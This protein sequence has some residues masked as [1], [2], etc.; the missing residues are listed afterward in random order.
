MCWIDRISRLCVRAI[1]LALLCGVLGATTETQAR[2]AEATPG[3]FSRALAQS[4]EQAP[5]DHRAFYAA[6]ALTPLWIE[7][8][9][10][11]ARDLITALKV[12]GAHAL[13]PAR[14]APERLEA[15]MIASSASPQHAAQAELALTRAYL[16]YAR[17]VSS[18]LLDPR[19]VSSMIRRDAPRP[20]PLALLRAAATAPDMA[21]HLAALAPAD[22]DYARL[23]AALAALRGQAER[24]DW[25]APLPS[26]PTL[27]QGDAGPRVALMRARLVRLGDAAPPETDTDPAFFDEGLAQA[28]RRFQ[29]RHGLDDDAAMGPLT[30]AALNVSAAE[31]ASQIAVNLERMRWLNT[32]LGE[33]RIVVNQADFTVKLIDGDATLFHERVV[34]GTLRD[35][36]PEFSDEMEYLVLNPSWHVPRSIATREI[37]P[38]LKE[39]P[40]YL[41]DRNMLLTRLDGAPPPDDPAAHDFTRYS[42]SDFPYRIRQR[43]DAGNALGRVKFMFPNDYA[44]YLHD[45][46]AKRLFARAMR[47][48]SHGCVRV[49]DPLRLAELLLAP[50]VADAPGFVASVLAQGRERYVT[51][52]QPVAVHLHY[53]TVTF[54]DDGAPNFLADVYSRDAAALEGLRRAGVAVPGI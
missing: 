3:A 25:G 41:R 34:I 18:G 29:R 50:Q 14:Y 6:N 12:S 46:P 35:Q 36:T 31:R 5:R 43:P 17:D 30:R 44:I 28:L 8:E 37:L 54:E 13:P 38:L 32:H 27:R 15:M 40:A 39:D 4:L 10:R 23:Q 49:R 33:R 53:R 21:A 26:G 42:A 2:T 47:A 11:A 9:M 20:D 52:A 48:F 16:L 24:G 45:T 51:L 1:T 19:S 7:G 22:P